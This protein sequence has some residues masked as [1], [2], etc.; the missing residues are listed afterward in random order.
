V[1]VSGRFWLP[2]PVEVD[3]DVMAAM[4]RPVIG[5]RTVAG[6]ALAE[7]LQ[8]GLKQLFN[9]DRPVIVATC[10]AT[11]LMES[12]I[13]SGVR[14]RL[15][16]VVSGT[17][18][19]RFARIAERCDKE[20]VRLHVPRGGVLEPE[21]LKLMLSGPPVD[22]VSLV[23][24]ETSTGAVAP[25]ADLLPLF[26]TLGDIVT[27]VDAVGSLGGMPVEPEEWGADFVIGA[28]QK[29]LG[30]PPGLAFA[31]ASERFLTRALKLEDRGLYLDAVALHHAADDGRF[32]QT[33][34]LPIIHA[35]DRQLERIIEGG[36]EQRFARHR[37]M[38]E[39]IEH[40]A[41]HQGNMSL[42]A[43]TS[44][45]ADT[46]SAIRLPAGT[47]SAAVIGQLDRDG[48]QVAAGL[49]DDLEQVIRIGHMG[50]ASVDQLEHLLATL[51]ARV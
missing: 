15:L 44:R 47:T 30:L 1:S 33:P 17:F 9:T 25:V 6:H 20:V 22:A 34:A 28:S 49:D 39:R 29:A 41:L 35:L 23:H 51:D 7:R 24:V 38:R 50:D 13:R 48:F 21:Q 42:M 37:A 36:L 19:E 12:A 31:A 14:E 45:R 10:S 18:G 32:P 4:S 11:G 27:I 43:P 40:W 8:R 16:A 2:G 5:H 26:D 46:V 3:P